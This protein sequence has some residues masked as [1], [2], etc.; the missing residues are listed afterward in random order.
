MTANDPRTLALED[1][2]RALRDVADMD[3]TRPAV[4]D[5][6]KVARRSLD[7]ISSLL[8]FPVNKYGRTPRP[9]EPFALPKEDD[10]DARY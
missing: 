1:A 9:G 10:D 5:P 2:L 7:R 6:E 8:G 4:S 3:A